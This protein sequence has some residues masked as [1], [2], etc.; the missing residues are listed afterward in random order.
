[1]WKLQCR[2]GN[3]ELLQMLAPRQMQSLLCPALLMLRLAHRL[4]LSRQQALQH[5]PP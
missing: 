2:L 5:A 4:M 1:M 3:Q